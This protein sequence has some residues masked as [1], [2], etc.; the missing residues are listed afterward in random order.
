[1]TEDKISAT[2]SGMLAKVHQ[3]TSSKEI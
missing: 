1:V 3:R 2:N